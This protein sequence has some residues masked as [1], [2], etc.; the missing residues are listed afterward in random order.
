MFTDKKIHVLV[1]IGMVTDILDPWVSDRIKSRQTLY[2]VNSASLVAL[3][4]E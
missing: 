3:C 2:E 1:C 4:A